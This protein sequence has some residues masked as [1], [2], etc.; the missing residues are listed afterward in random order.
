MIR[1]RHKLFIHGLRFFD[2]A[3]LAL[4][5]FITVA[6]AKGVQSWPQ[7]YIVFQREYKLI[8]SLA[9]IAILAGWYVIYNRFV[10]YNTNQF[11]PILRQ[12]WVH[13]KAST[14][15]AFL[16]LLISVLFEFETLNLKSIA[17]FWALNIGLGSAFRFFLRFALVFTAF[18]ESS[19]RNIIIIG[20]GKEAKAI[21]KAILKRK[22]LGYQ[23]CG[24]VSVDSE[25]TDLDETKAIGSLPDLPRIL[26]KEKVDE[27]IIAVNLKESLAN[28][29]RF[30]ILTKAVAYGKDL[31]LVVRLFPGNSLEGIIDNL[32]VETFEN[33]QVVTLFRESHIIQLFVKRVM[34]IFISGIMLIL[35]SPLFIIL[36]IAIKLDSQGPILFAQKRVGMNKRKFKL[37]KFRSMVVNAEEL[38]EALA[39]QNEVD[40]PVFK[41]KNDPRITRVG[42]FIRKTSMDEL[43]Q[44]WN[45]FIGDISLVGPRPPLFSEVDQYDWLFRRRISVKPGITCLWQVSGRNDL[46]FDEWMELDKEYIENWSIWL[47]IKILFMTMPTVLL[48]R[49][50]S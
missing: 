31:G 6:I 3:A 35:L 1:L 8:E 23:I 29:M 9:L 44:L 46:S 17:L 2:Q 36:A 27:I 10:Q 15:T 16:V 14:T 13:V 28:V 49:G 20:T 34:D 43:P 50:A 7:V 42:R 5:L 19:R 12:L 32:K 18:S 11:I 30:K 41:I 25:G 40:G 21:S 22:E 39:D 33:Q 26:E 4:S 47:D 45:A 38:R 37:F 48:G 24:F